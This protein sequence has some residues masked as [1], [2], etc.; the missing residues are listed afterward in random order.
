MKELVNNLCEKINSF[1]DEHRLLKDGVNLIP[2]ASDVYNGIVGI[3][4]YSNNLKLDY[5]WHCIK[6]D[7][8]IEQSINQIYNYVSNEERAFYI[9]SEFRKIIL[10]SSIIS[11]SIIAYIMGQVVCENRKCTHTEVIISNALTN[12]TDYDLENFIFLCNNCISVLGEYETIDIYKVEEE[13]KSSFQCTI[14]ICVAHGLFVTDSEI[15]VDDGIFQ[16]LYYIKT[17]L[18]NELLEY[19]DKVKQLLQYKSNS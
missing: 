15:Q 9:S 8:N 18:C 12:M 6:K 11:S 10:S 19:I 3:A 13:K 14:Q 1:T 5:A 16:G 4:N 2:Y 17:G 7:L